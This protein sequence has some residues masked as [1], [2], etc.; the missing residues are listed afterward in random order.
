VIWIR[1]GFFGLGLGHRHREHPVSRG[2]GDVAR[3]SLRDHD[4]F[5]VPH[6]AVPLQQAR[7]DG[8]APSPG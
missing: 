3:L 4:L 7:D 6:V 2:R 5:L 1:R 8:A